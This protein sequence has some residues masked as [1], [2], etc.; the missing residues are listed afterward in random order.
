MSKFPQNAT[1]FPV[2]TVKAL[3]RIPHQLSTTAAA[4]HCQLSQAR[5]KFA[6]SETQTWRAAT[7]SV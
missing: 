4:D 6:S 2:D 3:E 5:R 1:L 7:V